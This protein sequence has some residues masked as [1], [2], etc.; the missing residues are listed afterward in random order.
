MIDNV[1]K[2]AKLKCHK[3]QPSDV[4]I[5]QTTDSLILANW[6][7]CCTCGSI[8]DISYHT[9]YLIGEFFYKSKK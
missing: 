1:I 8:N 9:L 3:A 6:N 5:L 4:S 7:S 2:E